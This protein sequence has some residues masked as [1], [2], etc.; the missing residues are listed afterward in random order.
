MSGVTDQVEAV[1]LA[2]CMDQPV[3]STGELPLLKSS[4]KSFRSGALE[5]PPPPKSCEIT[6]V[7]D[8][9]GVG[10][11][12]GVAL[13]EGEG[14]GDGVAVGVGAGVGEAVGEGIGVALGEGEGEGIGAGVA[15]GE[16]VGV[17]VGGG[18]GVG[19]GIGVRMKREPSSL[20]PG[21]KGR[22][23]LPGAVEWGEKLPVRSGERVSD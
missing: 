13:G 21:L 17:G 18:V 22:F 14:V 12:I 15:D 11:G 5:L 7:R 3:R 4:M 6:T 10:L 23:S 19:V 8:G 9:L 1:A 16:T 20:V 2:Y